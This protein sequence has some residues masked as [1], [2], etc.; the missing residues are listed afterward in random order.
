MGTD[1]QQPKDGTRDVVLPGTVTDLV[2]GTREVLGLVKDLRE[3]VGWGID[4]LDKGRRRR[5]AKSVDGL[6]FGPHLSREPLERIA[7][8]QGTA[9]DYEMIALRLGESAGNIE[10]N[11][12]RLERYR[13]RLREDYGLEAANKLTAIIHGVG[14]KMPLRRSLLELVN[15]AKDQFSQEHQQFLAQRILRSIDRLNTNLIELHDLIARPAR[16]HD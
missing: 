8:E 11:V 14:G 4:A 1:S 2:K 12:A 10:E 16:G 13:D 7:A 9:E 15:C 6:T 5:A 3:F